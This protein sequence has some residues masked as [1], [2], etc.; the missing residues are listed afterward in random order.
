MKSSTA[1]RMNLRGRLRGLAVVDEEGDGERLGGLGDLEDLA[2]G[3]VL[4]HPEV[5]DGKAG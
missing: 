2:R 4:A 1:S 3:A 5:V